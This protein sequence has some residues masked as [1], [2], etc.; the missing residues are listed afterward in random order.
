MRWW[1]IAGAL[2][3]IGILLLETLAPVI[4][5]ILDIIRFVPSS[6]GEPL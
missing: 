3:L 6:L 2:F 5:G 4:Q 1:H